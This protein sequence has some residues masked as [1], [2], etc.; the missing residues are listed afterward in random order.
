V[1]SAI[2]TSDLVR[3]IPADL[4]PIEVRNN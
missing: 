3:Y 1:L 2:V 4:N